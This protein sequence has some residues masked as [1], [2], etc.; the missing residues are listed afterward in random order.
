MSDIGLDM[1][2]LLSLDGFPGTFESDIVAHEPL[3]L[4]PVE[5]NPENRAFDLVADYE[6]ARRTI[7]YQNQML[8]DA[9]KIYLE[10]AKNTESP[11]ML[12]A[13]TGLMQQMNTSTR[14]FMNLHKEMKAITEQKTETNNKP[15]QPAAVIQ[16]NNVFVGSA[17]DLLD[18]VEDEENG[19]T[20]E[21]EKC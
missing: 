5:S 8:M 20:I 11:K 10:L 17:S 15:A 16:A 3:E 4:V 9:A 18:E 21:G 13:F 1:N 2:Q 19:Y 7:H 12:Q 14:E 6:Q